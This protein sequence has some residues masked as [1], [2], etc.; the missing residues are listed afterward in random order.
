MA[1]WLKEFL[2]WPLKIVSKYITVL[3]EFSV[4]ADVKNQVIATLNFDQRLLKILEREFMR[5]LMPL[6]VS[7][8]SI[9]GKCIDQM[10]K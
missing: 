1:Q 10:F 2:R 7:T 6:G 5:Y 4:L 9:H 3:T 8:C